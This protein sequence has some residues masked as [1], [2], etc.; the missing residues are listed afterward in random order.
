MAYGSAYP[1]HPAEGQRIS[2]FSS[3]TNVADEPDA[4]PT[5]TAAA[6]TLVVAPAV[7]RRQ[8]WLA[9]DPSSRSQ[10]PVD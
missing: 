3:P 10:Y 1:P 8:H 7:D 2:P 9:Y 4:W 5:S 6:T